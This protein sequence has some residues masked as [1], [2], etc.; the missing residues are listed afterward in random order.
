MTCNSS[1]NSGDKYNASVLAAENVN[2]DRHAHIS[3]TNDPSNGCCLG[4]GYGPIDT[5]VELYVAAADPEG[6]LSSNSNNVTLTIHGFLGT[7]HSV[8]YRSPSRDEDSEEHES[9]I[10]IAPHSF[11]RGMFSWFP[12]VR[13]F[14][15]RHSSHCMLLTLCF[16]LHKPS[17][18]R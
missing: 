18:F 5:E 7:F 6:M 8:L 13:L 2:N 10:S 4:C 14:S 12:L 15:R 17:T 3:F 11:S 9:V 16:V 1:A